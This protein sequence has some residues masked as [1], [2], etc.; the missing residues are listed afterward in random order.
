MR[1]GFKRAAIL[2]ALVSV[3][4]LGACEKLE[5][6]PGK[7]EVL[8]LVPPAALL[9]CQRAP[10]VPGET[11]DDKEIGLY[12]LHLEEAHSDCER[13]LKAVE[14]WSKEKAPE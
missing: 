4:L 3:P 12:I 6:L 1:Q 13:K 2:P 10:E 7:T 8:K 14:D 5:V 9:S 11:A